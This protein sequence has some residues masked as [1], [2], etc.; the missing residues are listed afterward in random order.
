MVILQDDNDD[1]KSLLVSGTPITQQHL[2]CDNDEG[3]NTCTI[4]GVN[5]EGSTSAD[6]DDGKSDTP[7]LESSLQ[8]EGTSD[9]PIISYFGD[10]YMLDSTALF[11]K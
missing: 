7:S 8:S 9:G 6:K 11:V 1:Y 4:T 10:L 2:G 5:V 3:S